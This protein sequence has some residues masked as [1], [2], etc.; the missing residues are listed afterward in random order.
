M[1]TLKLGFNKDI[2][3]QKYH[4]DKEFIS[5]S[6]LKLLYKNPREFH[7][8]YVLGEDQNSMNQSALDMG[9]YIHAQILEPHLVETDFAIFEGAMRRGKAWEEFKSNNEGKILLTKSQDALSQKLMKNYRE[10]KVVIGKHG[11]ENEVPVSSFFEDGAAE[12]T[13]CVVL[14]GVKVKVRFDYRREFEDFGSINDVKTTNEYISTPKQVMAI[15]R[16][17]GYDVSAALYTDAVAQE[18]GKNHD[19]YFTFLSKKDG[20]CRIFRA[21]EEFLA[22]G[23]RKYQTAI[24]QLKEARES[25]IWYKNN[26]EELG[27]IED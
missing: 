22:G 14:N 9:T 1:S 26:I 27:A 3:N 24:E 7:R 12:E 2:E 11:F 8:I 25:G 20:A 19:F 21:S 10:A 18:T 5:S 23:R 15:C 6:G 16:T 4:D 17:W 13:L